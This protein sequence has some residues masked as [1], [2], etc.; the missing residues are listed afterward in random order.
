MN[1]G[2]IHHKVRK[3]INAQDVICIRR[4]YRVGFTLLRIASAY[5]YSTNGISDIVNYKTWRHVV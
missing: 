1:K 3:R 4:L 5:G 2:S